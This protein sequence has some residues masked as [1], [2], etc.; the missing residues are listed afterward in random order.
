MFTKERQ[1]VCK[2]C[3]GHYNNKTKSK[4]KEV[5]C[6]MATKRMNTEKSVALVIPQETEFKRRFVHHV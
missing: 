2:S 4:L 3:V 1:K 6:K 5:F